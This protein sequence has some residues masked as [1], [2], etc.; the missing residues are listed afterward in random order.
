MPGIHPASKTPTPG[1]RSRRGRYS[2]VALAAVLASTTAIEVIH[3][4]VAVAATPAPVMTGFVPLESNATQKSMENVN[5]DA[6]LTLDFTVGVTNAGDGAVMYYDHWEDGF[7]P[8]LTN[9]PGGS[10]TEVWGDGVP[11]NGNA[12]TFCTTCTG[13]LLPAGAV[14]VL[15]NFITT[16]RIQS[17]IRWDGRDRVS[18][19]RGFA[20]TAGGFSSPLG[21]V[22]AASASAYDTSKWGTDY[23]VP[24]GE[25]M[26]AIAGTGNP[27]GT[28][29]L[30][31]M[32]A[33]DDTVVNVDKD[34][35]GTMNDFSATIDR[36]EVAHVDGGVS[37]GAHV[38]STKPVQVHESAGDVG[39]AYELRWFTLFSTPLLTSDYLNPV[40]SS[41][42]SQRTITYLFNPGTSTISV[43]AD[44]TGCP[45]AGAPLSINAKSGVSFPSPLGQAVRFTSAAN[46]T[47]RR[48]RRDG[49][50]E[51]RRTRSGRRRQARA[52]TGG[53]VSCQRT[54]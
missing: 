5:S 18:S 12:A 15:R 44:C 2:L 24:V 26:P 25:N 43:T 53:S 54:C 37:A 34:G 20:I 32:A 16:P 49:L 31:I 29:S 8:D 11:G 14:F 40:G 17:E 38:Q 27:F 45:G 42:D 46:A 21:S 3:A 6:D 51:R 48:G 19:T 1:R 30:Q 9:V 33:E 22:L 39:S 4:P 35:N 41:L 50:A 23:W 47:L 52:T 13:D 36:G 10:T 7:E 28:S